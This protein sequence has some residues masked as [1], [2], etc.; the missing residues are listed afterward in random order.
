MLQ[1]S[2][3]LGGQLRLTITKGHV[4]FLMGFAH[5]PGLNVPPLTEMTLDGLLEGLR[6]AAERT[7]LRLLVLCAHGELTVT[8]LTEILGQSQPRVSRHLKLMCESGLLERWSEGSWAFFRLAAKGDLAALAR[9]LAAK[10]PQDDPAVRRDLECLAT[11]RR[12]RAKDAA[13]FF[14]RNAV[15]WDAIR[16]L[17]ADDGEVESQML[18]L[19]P[20]ETVGDLLDIGTGTGRILELFAGRGASGVGIDNSREMLAMARANLARAGISRAYVRYGDMYHLP[21]AQPAFDAITIHQ[22]LHFADDPA[23]VIGEA[24]RVLKP[25]GRI[26]IVDFARH[27]L[28]HLRDELAHRRLGF[29]DSEVSG[30]LRAAGL[31]PSRV[32]H[33][34]GTQL[35][36]NLWSAQRAAVASRAAAMIHAGAAQ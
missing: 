9:D 13:D 28:E 2:H 14:A 3:K 12:A 29:G 1:K 24:A 11:I 7:R 30:W 8:E 25:G 35:T 6:A 10:V 23:A 32:V 31:A 18:K 26:V 5:D 4:Y 27:A 36:V 15:R 20:P 34:P 19:L 17:H 21:W 33:L 22:V 16:S